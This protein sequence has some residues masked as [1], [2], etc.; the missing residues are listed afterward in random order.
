[1]CSTLEFCSAFHPFIIMHLMMWFR[2]WSG[3]SFSLPY[4]FVS[5]WVL[6]LDFSILPSLWRIVFLY[7]ALPHFLSLWLADLVYGHVKH[8]FAL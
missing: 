6:V 2:V 7:G 1:V 3:R 5:F 4:K 8:S